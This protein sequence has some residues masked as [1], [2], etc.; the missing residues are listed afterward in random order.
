MGFLSFTCLAYI[1]D[2]F[3]PSDPSIEIQSIFCGYSECAEGLRPVD[4]VRYSLGSA[5][6]NCIYQRPYYSR[7]PAKRPLFGYYD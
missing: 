1:R 2:M 4:S 3:T 7:L 5:L 6:P